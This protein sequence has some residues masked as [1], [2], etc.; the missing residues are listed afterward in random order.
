MLKYFVLFFL[1]SFQTFA[2]INSTEIVCNNGDYQYGNATHKD[3][4]GNEYLIYTSENAFDSTYSMIL[5]KWDKNDS[6]VFQDCGVKIFSFSKSILKDPTR[7]N[8]FAYPIS[9]NI[10]V[11][12]SSNILIALNINTTGFN[13]D[14]LFTLSDIYIFKYDSLGIAQ[15]DSSGIKLFSKVK[16]G[17]VENFENLK[18]GSC[19]LLLTSKLFYPNSITQSKYVSING[20]G[21]IMYENDQEFLVERTYSQNYNFLR[22]F[23]LYKVNNKIFVSSFIYNSPTEFTIRTRKFSDIGTFEES[24]IDILTD[25]YALNRID[26][27]AEN[28]MAISQKDS[29]GEIRKFNVITG[30]EVKPTFII[31]KMPVEVFTNNQY[32]IYAFGDSISIVNRIQK[33]DSLGIKYFGSSGFPVQNSLMTWSEVSN[34]NDFL[35]FPDSSIGYVQ[36]YNSIVGTSAGFITYLKLTKNNTV[37]HPEQK[38]N[39]PCE[40]VNEYLIKAFIDNKDNSLNLYFSQQNRP[41]MRQSFYTFPKSLIP[42]FCAPISTRINRN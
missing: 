1:T 27:Q 30:F 24:S 14:S 35:Q 10:Q 9:A 33:V 34:A 39:D 19:H 16:N 18:N 4:H 28:V 21:S 41:I 26:I 17:T 15:W 25:E 3:K 38:V 12:D 8:Y 2:Q 36:T 11:D 5:Q 20:D 29:K 6:K 37:Q 7:K 22:D 31:E 32:L 13:Q 23:Y 40:D 42:S